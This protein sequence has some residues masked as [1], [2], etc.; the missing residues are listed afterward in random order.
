VGQ[1]RFVVKYDKEGYSTRLISNGGQALKVKVDYTE[2]TYRITDVKSGL[3]LVNGKAPSWRALLVKVKKDI[4]S[5]FEM[6]PLGSSNI[7]TNPINNK[8]RRLA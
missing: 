6:H 2:F 5:I 1:G 4:I 3:T 7:F 8:T